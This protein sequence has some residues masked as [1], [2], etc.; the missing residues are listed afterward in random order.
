MA[1]NSPDARLLP[2]VMSATPSRLPSLRL[3]GER[4]TKRCRLGVCTRSHSAEERCLFCGG[5]ASIPCRTSA[6]PVVMGPE[7]EVIKDRTYSG[8][9][10]AE[11]HDARQ[12]TT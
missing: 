11:N 9:W 10:R 2:I 8:A 7:A 3:L 5:S 1:G 6:P 4:F 12:L